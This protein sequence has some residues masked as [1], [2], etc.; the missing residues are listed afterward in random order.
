MGFCEDVHVGRK[1]DARNT[2]LSQ[3]TP[4]PLADFLAARP[5]FFQLPFPVV[6]PEVG[7]MSGPLRR[8]VSLH[9][10]FGNMR[11]TFAVRCVYIELDL[12]LKFHWPVNQGN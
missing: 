5:A 10:E 7:M 3:V 6:E 2:R 8:T 9:S 4:N 12:Q 1:A 11:K